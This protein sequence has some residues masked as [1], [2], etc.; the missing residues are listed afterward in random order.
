MI[1]LARPFI[2]FD[3]ETTG[4]NPDKD[5]IVSFAFQKFVGSFPDGLER[6][7]K[8][9]INPEM[10]IPREASFGVGGRY[11]GHGITDEMVK[12]CKTCGQ[13]R[14]DHEIY[15]VG[16]NPHC[17]SGFTPW[18]TF[19]QIAPSVA[20]GMSGVDFGGFNIRFDL[21]VTRRELSRSGIKEWDYDGAKIVDGFRLW[22]VAQ[23]R[24]LSDALKE[25]GGQD[26]TQAHD[27]GADVQSAIV[28]LIGQLERYPEILPR[29][30]ES[31]DALSW[32]GKI[33][34]EGKFAFN[35]SGVPVV[36][37]G[38]K[39]KGD[40][41]IMVDRGFY[42]WILREDFAPSTKRIARDALNGIFPQFTGA[43]PPADDEVM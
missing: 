15:G 21:Q 12:A 25:F 36:N 24:T 5:R 8:T 37:F 9:L 17:A 14:A 28:V 13:S 32:P 18:P 41:M 27:A 23:P 31:L 19:Q 4:P 20:K 6:R 16:L 7:Y 39:H 43:A 2:V 42:S 33:D 40:P 11:E 10:P 26:A 29:S 22:Q 30:V 34:S 3:L 1:T 38:K 35:E